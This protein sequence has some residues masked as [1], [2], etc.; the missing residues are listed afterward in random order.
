MYI[1]SFAYGTGSS[2]P[3]PYITVN[4]TMLYNVSNTKLTLQAYGGATGASYGS[5]IILNDGGKGGGNSSFID[6]TTTTC[7]MNSQHVCGINW[8]SQVYAT[9]MSATP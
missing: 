1:S 6:D 4:C 7:F 3:Q 8:K 5:K 2:G 9:K